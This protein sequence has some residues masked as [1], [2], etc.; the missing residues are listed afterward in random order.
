MQEQKVNFVT[1]KLTQEKGFD[2]C[3]NEAYLLDTEDGDEIKD[4]DWEQIMEDN[5]DVFEFI[6][7]APTQSVLQK[8]LREVHN[9]FVNA[10][11]YQGYPEVRFY[12]DI[13]ILGDDNYN[14][15]QDSDD[16]IYTYEQALELGLQEALKLIEL[17]NN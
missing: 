16:N 10:D 3:T 8:W 9:I 4:S 12:Y 1:A 7:Y 5:P 14:G 15:N 6:G 13:K 17:S 2:W 11:Y